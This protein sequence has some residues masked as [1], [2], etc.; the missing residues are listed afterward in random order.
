M[1][2]SIRRVKSK[3]VYRGYVV[4]LSV[5]TYRAN[6]DTFLRETIQHPA[7]VV[8]LPI[9]P[10]GRIVLIRQFRHAVGRFIYEIPAGTSEPGEPLL[11]CAKRELAEETGYSASRWRRVCRFYPA[12]GISTE[13]MVLYVARGLKPSNEKAAM[14]ED[15]YI[16][17]RIVSA[18]EALELVQTNQIVDAKSIIGILWGLNRIRWRLK[19]SGNKS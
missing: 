9:L 4:D 16:T 18:R 12:P 10:D 1:E 13:R 15:E 7:S 14:D 6:G 2:K 17:L 3:I 8:I 11:R 5:D 19:V